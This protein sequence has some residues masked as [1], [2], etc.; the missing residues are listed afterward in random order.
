MIPVATFKDQHVAL[1]GL[2]DAGLNLAL[3]LIEGGAHVKAWD[4]RKAYRDRAAAQKV[5]IEDLTCFDWGD[6]SA[7]IVEDASLLESEGQNR[8]VDLARAVEIPVR[9]AISVHADAVLENDAYQTVILT[10][11]HCQA[12]A[13][14]SSFL[15]NAAGLRVQNL[16]DTGSGLYQSGI[17]LCCLSAA[18]IAD[19][20]A[21]KPADALIALEPQEGDASADNDRLSHYAA[22]AQLATIVSV[23]APERA[24]L[25]RG[26]TDERALG[27]SA[28]M[29]LS[30][31]VYAAG[32]ELFE[33]I[34][35][36]A[37]RIGVLDPLWPREAV[38]AAI[39]LARRFDLD[40]DQIRHALPDWLGA[41]G[42]GH[43][44]FQSERIG[45]YDWSF[46]R[47][48]TDAVQ[49]LGGDTAMF[50]IAGPSLDPSI[51]QAIRR[52]PN[53]VERIYLANDKARAEPRLSRY[54]PTTRHKN[55]MSAFARAMHDAA[56]FKEAVRIVYAPGCPIDIVAE[57]GFQMVMQTL[58]SQAIEDDA[59]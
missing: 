55:L 36:R 14:L 27:V 50:W 5:N 44:I 34:T 4:D 29:I 16:N 48:I 47:S 10:G 59:A 12:S 9:V 26:R 31:G 28:R 56:Y 52:V 41:I 54:V 37:E 33:T 21:S 53:A 11:R 38:L 8:F 24:R 35:G 3:S 15:L 13:S 17:V 18:E 57:Q 40:I 43:S 1:L 25:I 46:A 6:L 20:R 32:D 42:Y 22:Q 30:R 23:H 58:F 19:L 51:A 45:V 39:A 7:L 2:G 49:I